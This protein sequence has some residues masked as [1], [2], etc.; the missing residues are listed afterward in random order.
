MT[1]TESLAD[2]TGNAVPAGA[3]PAAPCAA[4]PT[5]RTEAAPLAPRAHGTMPTMSS[6]VPPT[7]VMVGGQRAP[8]TGMRCGAVPPS[9]SPSEAI[10][11]AS[12]SADGRALPVVVGCAA[13]LVHLPEGELDRQVELHLLRIHVGH[14]EI[15]AGGPHPDPP[16]DPR[17]A[18]GVGGER[19]SERADHAAPL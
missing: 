12:G 6:S 16:P 1:C 10:R 4:P 14:L 8:A 5:A 9:T 18:L 11:G 13:R 3:L 17:G 7:S 2:A 15:E 19:R